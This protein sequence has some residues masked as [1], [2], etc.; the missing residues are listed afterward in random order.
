MTPSATDYLAVDDEIINRV[1]LYNADTGEPFETAEG[2]QIFGLLQA[3]NGAVDGD[4][5]VDAPNPENVQ[6]SFVY[7][8]RANPAL[9]NMQLV[10]LDAGQDV[11]F[12]LRLHRILVNMSYATMVMGGDPIP[13]VVT[14]VYYIPSFNGAVLANY[15]E[16]SIVVAVDTGEVRSV[17]VGGA[18][19][20]YLGKGT[21]ATLTGAA[22]DTTITDFDGLKTILVDCD[23]ADRTLVLPTLADN[24]GRPITIVKI[25]A[26]AD[27]VIL[28]GEG[29]ETINGAEEQAL[30]RR[31]QRMTVLGTPTEWVVL[32][33]DAV[34]DEVLLRTLNLW[35]GG[36]AGGP[37]G[38]AVAYL[39]SMDFAAAGGEEVVGS[40]VLGP[41]YIPGRGLEIE[42]LYSSDAA[43]ASNALFSTS[44][45][46]FRTGTD[47]DSNPPT[48]LHADNA[49]AVP[50]SAPVDVTTLS[51]RFEL[52]DG[53]GQ[54]N[55]LTPAVGDNIAVLLARDAGDPSA[56]VF[57]VY[58]EARVY[59][60]GA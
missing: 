21:P 51:P 5:I 12:G 8:P 25:D 26:G 33:G 10:N 54:I 43:A 55:G 30:S 56:A 16:G 23:G 45:A 32:E 42:F 50:E 46:L 28:D 38:A 14:S 53:A 18:N 13:D 11:R 36:P 59:M 3:A 2:E 47:T 7:L 34:P 9:N 49:N 40:F 41:D 22:A 58:I 44:T 60:M 48:N 15:P 1:D 27:Q 35:I 52:T 57:R 31:R 20:E 17:A 39:E 37:P 29:V 24:L 6:I 4:A 19:W